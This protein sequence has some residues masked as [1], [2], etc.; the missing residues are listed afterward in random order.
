VKI[1]ITLQPLSPSGFQARW[2]AEG[3]GCGGVQAKSI[4]AAKAGAV[5]EVLRAAAE[6]LDEGSMSIEDVLPIEEE[7]S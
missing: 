1:H 7:M 2:S 5:A 4:R 3:I 6:M